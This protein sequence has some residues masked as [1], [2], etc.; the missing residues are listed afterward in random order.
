PDFLASVSQLNPV[1]KDTQFADYHGHGWNFRAV[2]KRDRKGNLLDAR[3]LR[4]SQN[5]PKK[6][7]KAVHLSSI[8]VDVG[9]QCVDCHFAQDNHGDGYMKAEGMGA[10]EIQCQDC[11]ATVDK[12][13]TLKTSGPAASPY[14]RDL[15]LIRNPDGKKRFEW[16]GDKLIQRSAVTP[17]LEWTMA[18]LKNDSSPLSPT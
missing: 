10:V 14:G 12:L 16:I 11:H 13:P 18:L 3:G 4:V 7:Q 9:M 5:D 17:G 8:H 2:F 1:L 15:Q 6:F